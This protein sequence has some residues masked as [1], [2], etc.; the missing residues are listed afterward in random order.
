[1]LQGLGQ[2][3]HLLL[4]DVYLLIKPIMMGIIRYLAVLKENIEK[5]LSLLQAF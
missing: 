2:K 1:M 4:A 5:A 3:R